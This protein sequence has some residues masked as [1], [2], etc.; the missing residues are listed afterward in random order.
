VSPVGSWDY[1][2][3]G[4]P[5]GD[6]AGTLNVTKIKKQYAA[7]LNSQGSDLPFKKFAFDPKTKKASGDFD[8]QGMPI[9][10]GA[11]VKEND[12]AGNVS[13]DDAQFPFKAARKKSVSGKQ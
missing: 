4:T 11:M 3:T 12:M 10:F 7:T 6:Y 1:T 13:T 8:Y 2:I 5:N 9:S